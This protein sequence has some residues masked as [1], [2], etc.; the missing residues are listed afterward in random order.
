MVNF[1]SIQP[2]QLVCLDFLGLEDS[3]GGFNSILVITDHFTK[4]AQAIPTKNQLAHT[5]A[6]ILFDNFIVHYGFPEQLHSDQGRNFESSVI[7]HLC[8]LAGVRKTRTTPYHPMGNPVTERFNR[9]LLQMLRTL[10]TEQKANWKA[11][12]PALVHAYNSTR[13]HTTGYSPFY[14]MFG[15]QPRLAID[16]IL[17]LTGGES[18]S[19]IRGYVDNLQKQLGS[20][21]RIASEATKRSVQRHKYLYDLKVRGAVPGSG[22]G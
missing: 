14:L 3:K 8:K 11:F 17:G 20:A 1:E 21:Y 19:S 22:H 16:V 5:T 7:S 12:V 18:N 4:Y 15:R 13:N 10:T 2:M 9:T 6:K